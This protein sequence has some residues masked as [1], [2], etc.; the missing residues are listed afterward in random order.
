MNILVTG[1]A[2]YVGSHAVKCL[3]A[4]G[5][6][7]WVYDNLVYGHKSAAPADRLVVGDLHESEK[8]TKLLRD[9]QI[10]AVMHF[11]AYA[12]VGESVTDPAKY[13][14]N[15]VVGTLSLLDAMR[16]CGVQK[17]VFSSTCATYGVPQ[18]VPIPEDHPQAP[19]NPY[20][21]TK[22]VI[23]RAMEDYRHAYGLGYAALRYFNASG[24][25][26]DGSIGEDHDPETHLIP[27]ILDVAL[28]KRDSITVFGTDYP[29]P[30]GSCIRDYIHVDDL[31][32]AH[33]AALNK[34]A[35]GK[36]LKLNLGTGRG[37]SVKEVIEL[38]EEVTGKEIATLLGERREGD[39]P[40]LV[41]NPK[42]AEDAIGWKA[43]RSMRET[44]ESAWAW[45][46]AHPDGYA[47]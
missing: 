23:E 44:I 42:T 30:D 43:K 3:M 6:D 17:I 2:G 16:E 25:A 8:L 34:L 10:E 19:I 18:Q 7:V 33:L 4:N 36:S 5:H 21:Y 39:P 28:G 12:Y 35:P 1:G 22:L 24:A 45:H 27:L 40:E 41:A 9:N 14:Q 37:A 26:A 11:A 13:Y 46:S 29:T 15:N 32:D 38:C 31:A 47:D 20:G